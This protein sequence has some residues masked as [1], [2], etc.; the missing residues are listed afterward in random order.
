MTTIKVDLSNVW[1]TG[2]TNTSLE[3]V[4]KSNIQ[5]FFVKKEKSLKNIETRIEKE[6]EK[7]EQATESVQP[8]KKAIK[9]G[10]TK[11]TLNT[12]E[13]RIE[14]EEEATESVQPNKKTK[15]R[16]N[17]SHDEKNKY[18]IGID[19]AGRGPLFGRLYIAGVALPK[20]GSMDISL[21]K[22]SKQFTSRAKIL[23][24]Y[25]YIKAHAIAYHVHYIESEV[26]DK[27]NIRQAVLQGMRECAKQTMAK[28]DTKPYDNTNYKNKYFLMID[29]DDF[30]PYTAF[31]E[32][33]NSIEVIP[34]ETFIGGDNTYAAIAAASILAKVER[35][36]YIL[37]L[38][39]Q[40]PLLVERYK[41]NDHKGYGTKCH[42]AGIQQYGITQF[43]RKT[44]GSCK[45][46]ELNRI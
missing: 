44:F 9:L 33:T 20:D 11:N 31:N 12:I 43:H 42:L 41:M 21:I 8:N 38:C 45:L 3:K 30:T 25:N 7:E 5:D 22:D 1:P 37:E 36:N 46:A 14:K 26:I 39:N 10:K 27:I 4:K 15:K 29:G 19:E 24:V 6:E 34:H 35:D 23:S 28:L 13:T 40:Y 2:P 32:Q 17:I 16:I 18:E